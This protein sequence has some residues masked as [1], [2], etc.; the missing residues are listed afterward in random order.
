MREFWRGYVLHF[1]AYFCAVFRD[2]TK[3]FVGATGYKGDFD[4]AEF[5]MQFTK[6]IKDLIVRFF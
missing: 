5:D 1:S 4:E 3:D 2:T 6:S